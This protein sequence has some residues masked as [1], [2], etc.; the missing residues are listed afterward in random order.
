MSN[1]QLD[2]LMGRYSIQWVGRCQYATQQQKSDKIWGWFFYID[3]TVARSTRKTTFHKNL[4]VFWADTGKTISF[5]KQIN[6]RR[7]IERLVKKKTTDNGYKQIPIEE[8]LTLYDNLYDEM[9]N[10]F[11]FHLLA[12]NI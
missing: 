10:R 2:D 6:D 1:K 4:Y 7:L 12:N 9:T 3:P 8:L 5:K 11:V